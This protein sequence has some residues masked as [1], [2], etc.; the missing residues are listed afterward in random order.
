MHRR[1][2]NDRNGAVQVYSLNRLS[3]NRTTRSFNC[4]RA[5]E[6]NRAEEGLSLLPAKPLTLRG[7]NG[8]SDR[9]RTY[10]PLI[11]NQVRYQ[12]ALHSEAGKSIRFTTTSRKPRHAAAQLRISNRSVLPTSSVGAFH[13]RAAMQHAASCQPEARPCAVIAERGPALGMPSDD[14][15]IAFRP[16]GDHPSP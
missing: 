7:K 4:R 5:S 16:K 14:V 15:L 8:R 11:P 3:E 1:S 9:I 12:A 2:R 6:H 10:D 13:H